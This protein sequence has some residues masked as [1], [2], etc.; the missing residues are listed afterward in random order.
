MKEIDFKDLSLKEFQNKF[1]KGL[2]FGVVR[3]AFIYVKN[4]NQPQNSISTA[5]IIYAEPFKSRE[6]RQTGLMTEKEGN[7]I[8]IWKLQTETAK[9]QRELLTGKWAYHCR[10]MCIARLGEN[11]DCTLQKTLEFGDNRVVGVYEHRHRF[12]A[13][14]S[15][16]PEQT[17]APCIPK[18][19]ELADILAKNAL[20][21]YPEYLLQQEKRRW[22]LEHDKPQRNI[23][24]LPP[25]KE[26]ILKQ[27]LRFVEGVN[28]QS[29]L[30][31]KHIVSV[32]EY[33]KHRGE[34]L[35]QNIDI[36]GIDLFGDFEHL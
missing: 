31:A 29:F 34:Q 17:S 26:F 25:F 5:M 23:P 24:E 16:Q 6:L 2:P 8:S 12:A 35:K 33:I 36:A 9:A 11:Y 28:P 19:Q 32:E 14:V 13:V 27:P 15:L 22:H 20:A 21:H 18:I 10:H 7:R 3:Q 1:G 4:G 30:P